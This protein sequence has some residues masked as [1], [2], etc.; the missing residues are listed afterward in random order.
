MCIIS[1]RL[2]SNE[3]NTQKQQNQTCF[4]KNS[5]FLTQMSGE[6]SLHIFRHLTDMSALEHKLRVFTCNT[7][8][9]SFSHAVFKQCLETLTGTQINI[10]HPQFKCK[11]RDMNYYFYKSTLFLAFQG[12]LHF[13]STQDLGGSHFRVRS[14]TEKT[15]TL[16]NLQ[17]KLSQLPRRLPQQK[18]QSLPVV[19]FKR[20]ESQIMVSPPSSHL[21]LHVGNHPKIFSLALKPRRLLW[22]RFTAQCKGTFLLML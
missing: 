1:N 11:Q 2:L 10:F 18:H 17:W 6:F 20:N 7:C 13:C 5:F 16:H 12:S 14:T 9:H 8:D 19:V 3:Q 22:E 21:S 4:I 15:Q